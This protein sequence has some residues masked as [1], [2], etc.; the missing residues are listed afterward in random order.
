[1]PR[2]TNSNSNLIS[3]DWFTEPKEGKRVTSTST[4]EAKDITLFAQYALK[5]TKFYYVGDS[6]IFQTPNANATYR[7]LGSKGRL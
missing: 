5:E 3:L 6:Q 7:M 2:V 1:M 4:T